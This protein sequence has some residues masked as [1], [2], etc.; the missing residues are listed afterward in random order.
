MNKLWLLVNKKGCKHL[1]SRC[2]SQTDRLCFSLIR[3]PIHLP[4][5]LNPLLSLFLSLFGSI[6][7][8][9]RWLPP[10]LLSRRPLPRRRATR[11]A[12]DAFSRGFSVSFLTLS[13]DYQSEG[14]RGGRG[15]DA[16]Y[17]PDER[18]CLRD[19]RIRRRDAEAAVRARRWAGGRVSFRC[20]WGKYCVSAEQNVR[21]YNRQGQK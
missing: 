4:L 5:I 6:H 13:V 11:P 12:G 1:P 14:G 7:T 20:L 16:L 18:S 3:H 10:C 17:F 8:R 21:G 2:G 15:D 9:G 19:L